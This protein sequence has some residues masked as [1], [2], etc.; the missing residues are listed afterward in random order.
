M[1]GSFGPKTW[2][3]ITRPIYI[4][5]KWNLAAQKMSSTMEK[6]SSIAAAF[7]A[8]KLPSTDQLNGFIDWLM[9]FEFPAVQPSEN[10][11]S[12]QGRILANDIRGILDAYK[13]LNSNKN[14]DNVVQEALWHLTEGDVKTTMNSAGDAVDKNEASSD[15]DAVRSS[16]RTILSVVWHNLSSDGGFLPGD[17]ASFLRLSMADAAELVQDQAGRAKDSLR[18]IED[19]VQEGQRDSLGRDKKRLEEESDTRVAFEH[20]MDTL[21]NLGSG[22]IGAHQS[23]KEKTED[24]SDRASSQLWRSYYQACERA[25]KDPAYHSALSTLFDTIHKWVSRAFDKTSDD[26]LTLDTFVEDPSPEQHIHKALNE[27][28]TF[29]DRFAKPESSVDAVLDKAQRFLSAVR[30]NS[31]EF[32]PWV[33]KFFEHAHRSLE[34]PDYPSSEAADNVRRDLEQRRNTL[35]APD[36]DAARTW[37]DL[38]ETTRAFGSAVLADADIRRLREAHIQLGKDVENGLAEAGEKAVFEQQIW[39]WR[40]LFTVYAPRMLSQLK[41]LP[42]PRTEYVDD[43]TELVLE[44]LDISSFTLNPAHIFVRNTTDLDMHTSQTEPATTAVGTFTHIQLQA[45]QLALKDVSF[46]FKDKKAAA[47]RPSQVTGLLALTMPPQGVDVDIKLRLIKSAKEREA[48]RGYHHIEQLTVQIGHDVKLKVNDSNHGILLQLFK[49]A[50][51]KKF[52]E[53]LG[54]TLGEQLRVALD[55][56][57]GMAWDVQKR[58]EV[59]ADAGAGRGAA[60]AAA[61]WSEIGRLIR[62]RSWGMRATGTGVVLEESTRDGAKFAVG[63]EPQILSGEKRGPMGTGSE[64]LENRVRGQTGTSQ[65]A[66]D[67]KTQ[68]RGLVGEGKGQVSSF[69]RSV[70]EKSAMEKENPGWKSSAFDI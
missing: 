28:K 13:A 58:S 36:T 33:D 61:V 49:P 42:I 54:R 31:G 57:D 51:N 23:A 9:Q 55:G 8:G 25:Q 5:S 53:A 35:L 66:P 48:K 50:W 12:G 29:L 32:K 18:E 3:F 46:Y 43:D 22:V 17:F 21:K 41:D 69:K 40:D 4:R 10:T 6:S 63:A 52:R 20:N 60:L 30:G 11:L 45:V 27:F 16:L 37:A 15:I 59:F 39:F 14:Q 47:L 26:S 65:N 56:L 2:F 62:E 24:V 70:D 34:D 1:S 64:S 67:M 68:L 44:N 7:D 19:G 38:K